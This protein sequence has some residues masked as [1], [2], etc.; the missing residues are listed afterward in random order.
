MK[1]KIIIGI[2]IIAAFFAG[3]EF[4]NSHPSSS[5]FKRQNQSVYRGY[6]SDASTYLMALNAYR[7]GDVPGSANIL[8]NSLECSLSALNNGYKTLAEEHDPSIFEIVKEARVYRAKYP[9]GCAN[10]KMTPE[11][12][13]TITARVDHVLS[14]GM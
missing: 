1:A 10:A 12:E 13:Q 11:V 7:R 2:F 8:E 4:G 9:W 6:A 14:L 5:F 3:V